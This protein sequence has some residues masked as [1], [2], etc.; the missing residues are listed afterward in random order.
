VSR[1]RRHP[2]LLVAAIAPSSVHVYL[3]YRCIIYARSTYNPSH[4]S[5]PV[6]GKEKSKRE[7]LLR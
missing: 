7:L 2:S 5:I 3:E 6:I 4:P 1:G